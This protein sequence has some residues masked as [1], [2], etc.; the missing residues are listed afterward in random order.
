MKLHFEDSL[1]HQ[2]AAIE[3]VCDLFR[4]QETCQTAFTVTRAPAGTQGALPLAP[5]RTTSDLGIG[6]RLTLP[7]AQ[8]QQNLGA[9]QLRNAVAPSG[10]PGL[11][12]FTVEME[13]GTGKTYVYLRT[14]FE[15]NKRYG[16][17]KFVIVVPSVAIK[18]GVFKSLQVMAAHFGALYANPPFNYAVYDAARLGDVRT[19]ATSAGMEV[20][21][22][23]VGAI[24]KFGDEAEALAEQADASSRSERTRNV[25]YRASEKTGGEKP[26][27][28][29][30]ATCPIVLV[31]EPQSV[32]GG[33]EGRG[34]Q[35]L[36]RMQPLCTLRYSATHVD[37]RQMVY[38]LDAVDAYE[39]GLVK[40]IEVAAGTVCG[41]SNLPYVRLLAV[42]AT[43]GRVTATV[44]LDVER[45]GRVYREAV[46]V[47]DGDDLAQHTGRSV[48]AHCRVGELRA[49]RGAER[50]ELLTA[51]DA[52]WLGRG[53]AH[54]DVAPL[55]L[56]RQMIRRTIQEHLDKEKRL[57]PL[58]IKVLSL[59][60][61]DEVA[62]Y[63]QYDAR[64]M[65]LPGVYAQVF[66]EEYEALRDHPDYRSLFAE[67]GMDVA[68]AE[69]HGGYFSVDKK[70]VA[71]R[72]VDVLRD[73]RGDTKADDD[74]YRLIMRD[75]ER[76]LDMATPLRFIFS[77]SALRE[78]WDNPNVFQICTLRDIRSERERRQSI[79]RGLRLCVNQQGER[80]RGPG[81][82]TLTVIANESYESFAEGLQQELEDPATGTGLR[83]GV[84]AVDQFA[85]I[86]V[87]D[88]DGQVRALGLAASTALFNAL[89]AGAYI[90]AKGKVTDPLRE[91]LRRGTLP[92]PAEAEICRSAVEAMLRKLTGR[93]HIRNADQRV[94]AIPLR[95]AVFESADFRALWARIKHRTHYRVQFNSVALVQHCT[96]ALQQLPPTQRATLEWQ[97]ATLAITAAGVATAARRTAAPDALDTTAFALPDILTEL[98]ERTQLTRRSLQQILAGSGRLDDLQRNPQ[99]FLERAAGAIH[100]CRQL[101]LVDGIA[102]QRIGTG[103]H[104][105]QDLFVQRPLRG[106]RDGLLMDAQK[107]VHEHMS[108]ESQA[109]RD[110]ALALERSDAVLLYAKLPH[111]FQIPTPLGNYTPDWA[112]VTTAPDGQRQYVVVE[113]KGSLAS[114]NQS[115]QE[116]AKIHC[117]Q[118][119]FA[120]LATGDAPA[121]YVV[122][123]DVD[124]LLAQL[125]A[126]PAP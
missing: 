14:L 48:Y 109:E 68:A 97:T 89:H 113:T 31:D 64:G 51:G 91:A 34:R 25:M 56:Q 49:G 119:H 98:Q 41:A 5:G 76:L 53:E 75:K 87:S 52:L 9:V 10:V 81:I 45:G 44:E 111:W 79:G 93:L 40:Q 110:F 32:D 36:A 115:P 80:V 100:R 67:P 88:A 26:I 117:A 19:F 94:A 2:L 66:E 16:F 84:V 99:V 102:C 105:A 120:A 78:G 73:T 104:Y 43:R 82:N 6:N 65:A 122:A 123:R 74:T 37:K 15:L 21:V 20:L 69:V 55:V 90:T 13:T 35:A 92:L 106:Y 27:D 96:H 38:A 71:G 112:V 11:R 46:T 108:F 58:G 72:N 62:R 125:A 59:F 86:P 116:Q 101:L 103:Q 4:G 60:F 39:Q 61:I 63:R 1:P 30:R 17:T 12:D 124:S 47:S 23:T 114:E 70:K 95:K 18:E 77:H 22:M 28:L 57:R 8:L 42:K 85:A 50:L 107:A 121:R 7:D 3:A 126:D 118:A 83:F 54:G 29:I 33:L 24:N